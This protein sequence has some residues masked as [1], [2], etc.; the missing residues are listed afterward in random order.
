[1]R[2]AELDGGAR[3]V[4]RLRKIV[5]VF[6]EVIVRRHNLRGGVDKHARVI[7]VATLLLGDSSVRRVGAVAQRP[8]RVKGTGVEGV[9]NLQLGNIAA[10]HRRDDQRVRPGQADGIVGI[11]AA[12]EI[13]LKKRIHRVEDAASLAARKDDLVTTDGDAVAFVA[14]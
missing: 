2:G 13:L 14:Q 11:E 6:L 3:A 8:D 9:A 5:R 4:G 7:H 10:V 1:M 12:A